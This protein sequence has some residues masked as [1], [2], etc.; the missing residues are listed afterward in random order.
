MRDVARNDDE[1]DAPFSSLQATQTPWT[2]NL[3]SST[4]NT[5]NTR[6]AETLH[7]LEIGKMDS[8]ETSTSAN[9]MRIEMSIDVHSNNVEHLPPLD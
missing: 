7:L 2:P 4:R 5:S 3:V 1:K 9:L 8:L 6:R